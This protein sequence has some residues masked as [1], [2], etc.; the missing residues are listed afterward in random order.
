[1]RN[2]TGSRQLRL[3]QA[4]H[5]NPFELPAFPDPNRLPLWRRP[6]MRFSLL[7]V[8]AAAEE[9]SPGAPDDV[10]LRGLLI[11]GTFPNCSVDFLL[12]RLAEVRAWAGTPF[13]RAFIDREL[14]RAQEVM[15]AGLKPRGL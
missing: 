9:R 8:V 13:G 6:M 14:E 5:F 15:N 7:V 1:M 3:V 10:L 2:D 4:V 11:R 12:E